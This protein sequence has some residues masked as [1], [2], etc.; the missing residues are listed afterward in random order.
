MAANKSQEKSVPLKMHGC[1]LPFGSSAR[2]PVALLESLITVHVFP[3]ADALFTNYSSV[4]SFS[5]HLQFTFQKGNYYIDQSEKDTQHTRLWTLN[6]TNQR[7]LVRK[8]QSLIENKRA[9]PWFLVDNLPF[10]CK[11]KLVCS[12]RWTEIIESKG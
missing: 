5:W 7:T 9:W 4:F 8:L 1:L 11:W 10:S 6:T 2:I 3:V 12:N